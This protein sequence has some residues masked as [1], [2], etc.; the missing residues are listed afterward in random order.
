MTRDDL[1]KRICPITRVYDCNNSDTTY[2]CDDCKQLLSKMFDE[3]D[4]HVIEQYK[5]DTNLK[6][7]IREIHDRVAQEMYCKGIDDF[8]EKIELKYLGVNPDEL[9]EKYYP[10]EICEQIKE[11]AK[12]LKEQIC[13]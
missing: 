9:Y 4:K 6:D 11:I 8:V 10:R 5:A 7:T 13:Q 3:Y 12:Q 2:L 1:L